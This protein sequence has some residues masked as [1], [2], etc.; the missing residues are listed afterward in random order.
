MNLPTITRAFGDRSELGLA[1]NQKF[2]VLLHV[3]V[4]LIDSGMLPKDSDL[5]PTRT[6]SQALGL[7][8]ATVAKAYEHLLFLGK[9]QS[10]QG[11]R[12]WVAPI[13]YP[14]GESQSAPLMAKE[15]N[16]S[17]LG[18]AFL[19]QSPKV[20]STESSVH[21]LQP[22]VP[23]LDL[24]PVNQWRSLTN[25]YWRN[26]RLSGLTYS[27]TAGQ[28]V[29]KQ[30]LAQLLFSERGIRCEP[31]QIAVVSGSVQSL[32][33]VGSLLLNPGDSVALENPTFPNVHRIF[34]GLR[35][36]KIELKSELGEP[37]GAA[38]LAHVATSEAYPV[39]P[40]LGLERRGEL[41]DQLA[42][43]GGYLIEND[44]E[45]SV[46]QP[47]SNSLLAHH[48]YRSNI[49]YLS[50]FNRV[51][52]PS[53]RIGFMVLPHE[54]VRPMHALMGQSHRFVS[55]SAQ[56]VL[57]EFIQ[58]GHWQQHT[59]HLQ[60]AISSRKAA[61]HEAVRLHFPSDWVLQSA[62]GAQHACLISPGGTSIPD[63]L[64][65]R[66]NQQGIH[67]HFL[68]DHYWTGSPQYG[69]VLG[70]GSVHES[71]MNHW[72]SVLSEQLPPK[73]ATKLDYKK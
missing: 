20:R 39:G 36:H 35:A 62:H 24:F 22:G 63:R 57:H 54:L 65:A 5:P 15:P 58:A 29:L 41:A 23:P 33:L 26:V 21:P 71:Q 17:D 67:P 3:L 34:S 28:Q 43:Q 64:R 31:D 4:E 55:T 2:S 6:M 49:I 46:G 37:L 27:S 19:A 10:L 25:D 72:V 7:S 12:V 51:L 70:T 13:H 52:H 30:T 66:F 56:T 59:K 60:R 42:A 61:L 50:T 9:A 53:I 68:E 69:L 45:H 47:S 73:T 48:D 38:R 32:F 40:A 8:R 44:Y 1:K 18:R 16:L 14:S 11:S